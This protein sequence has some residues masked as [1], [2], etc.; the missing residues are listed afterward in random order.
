M[1]GN[2]HH[3]WELKPLSIL[4]NDQLTGDA[5]LPG[6]LFTVQPPAVVLCQC[7]GAL[8]SGES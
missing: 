7:D 2:E 4:E 1:A 5:A 3:K 8:S 6:S